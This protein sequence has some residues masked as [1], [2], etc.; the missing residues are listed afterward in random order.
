MGKARIISGGAA[1]NY[2]IEILEDRS[3]A[4]AIRSELQQKIS[5]LDVKI[6]ES[7]AR[8]SI[9]ESALD[10]ALIAQDAAIDQYHQ[11][12]RDTGSSSVDL[13]KYATAS[14]MAASE[15]DQ[16]K[17]AGRLF[18]IDRA[19]AQSRI[20]MIDALPP[21][22]QRSAWCAD[23]SENLSG[24]V[25]TGE[26][27]GEAGQVIIKPGFHDDAAWSGQADGAFQP[28]LAGTA[29]SVF[30]NLAM[31]PGWQ[32]WRPTFRVGTIDSINGDICD[33][34]LDPATSSQQGI[35][36]NYRTKYYSVP[37]MYMD[38]NGDAFYPGDKVLL[39]FS[40]NTDSPSVVGFP[41]EPAECEPCCD[42]RVLVHGNDFPHAP[43]PQGGHN[44]DT[45]PIPIG[46]VI[47]G[48]TSSSKLRVTHARPD[49]SF[50]INDYGM[51][52]R[53]MQYILEKSGRCA[54]KMVHT[55]PIVLPGYTREHRSRYEFILTH[56]HVRM[57]YDVDT[58]PINLGVGPPHGW[59]TLI[60]WVY[61]NGA[62]ME[63]STV[64]LPAKLNAQGRLD[65]EITSVYVPWYEDYEP[66]VS[67]WAVAT[68]RYVG[69]LTIELGCY[70][71]DA[72]SVVFPSDI[73][74][75]PMPEYI[76]PD[77]DNGWPTRPPE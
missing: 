27:P 6:S 37:I 11:D 56:D 44:P 26:V 74:P 30:Y 63:R 2:Q 39:A 71:K 1:G 24:I 12:I 42:A 41:D 75:V 55:H 32:K 43:L 4:D 76:V 70:D 57:R 25:A 8:L 69:S 19:S 68:G 17:M 23:Y 66:M 21:L 38:C 18:E 33:V 13:N 77:P 20:Q 65:T 36:V 52:N 3:R 64:L 7:S 9:L 61:Y 22:R 40:G 45:L 16:E 47:E 28:A 53:F 15:R 67:K 46:T 35:N 62:V 48:M 72:G 51:D 50:G 10:T 31:T 58:L 34:T 5:A 59:L 14:I 49:G 73:G 60:R 29:A 54:H